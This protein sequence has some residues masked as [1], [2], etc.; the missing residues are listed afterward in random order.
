MNSKLLLFALAGWFAFPVMG[1]Y[2]QTSIRLNDKVFRFAT[3][4]ERLLAPEDKGLINRLAYALSEEYE[5][6]QRMD[7]LLVD[8]DNAAISQMAEIWMNMAIAHY[9]LADVNV[10]SAG[11]E[12]GRIKS[13]ALK[14]FETWNF[15][16]S[17]D[18]IQPDHLITV[19]QGRH[20]WTLFAK[21]IE[22]E[23]R[24]DLVLFVDSYC[25]D[26]YLGGALR[27]LQSLP[28]ALGPSPACMKN[29]EVDYQRLNAEIG[30]RIMFLTRQIKVNQVQ[31][32]NIRKQRLQDNR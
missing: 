16:V 26:Q 10:R 4:S 24:K 23:R 8:K 18:R 5:K 13:D 22:P 32:E 29:G 17:A 21:G 3:E 31:K 30:A 15:E 20:R 28:F 6:D 19:E 11:V 27:G 7:I 25:T 1:A 2:G 12:P 14:T 9:E